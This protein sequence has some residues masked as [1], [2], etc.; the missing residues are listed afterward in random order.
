MNVLC[1][2]WTKLKKIIFCCLWLSTLRIHKRK[3]S[4]AQHFMCI[5]SLS[6]C[7]KI[8]VLQ[9]NLFQCYKDFFS[10]FVIFQFLEWSFA[11]V[12]KSRGSICVYILKKK[13]FFLF[14]NRRHTTQIDCQVSCFQLLVVNSRIFWNGGWR[15]L[16]HS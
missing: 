6:L 9:K 16:A 14:L 2:I 5:L 1:A 12:E 10:V 3:F 15:T 8:I 7:I 11:R 4:L 13:F